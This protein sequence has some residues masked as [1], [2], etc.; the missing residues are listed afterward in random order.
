MALLHVRLLW[1]AV[2]ECSYLNCSRELVVN[3][4]DVP[5]SIKLK[6]GVVVALVQHRGRSRNMDDGV[7]RLR[8]ESRVQDGL[9]RRRSD[10]PP[11]HVGFECNVQ[12]N[13]RNNLAV[14]VLLVRHWDLLWRKD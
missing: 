8:N 10:L 6:L 7:E 1:S 9:H 11:V 5:D 4:H 13:L 14:G 3:T 12:F 2:A